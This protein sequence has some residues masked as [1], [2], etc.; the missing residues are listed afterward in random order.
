MTGA[1]L[2]RADLSLA[3]LDRTKLCNANLFR[4]QFRSSRLAATDLRNALLNQTAFQNV[5][6]SRVLNLAETTHRGPSFID[7][8][9]LVKSGILPT[10]F[11]RGCG[12]P[13][14]LIERF[15]ALLG[16]IAKYASCFI[17]YSTRDQLFAERLHGDLQ[18]KGVRCWF[19]QH[20]MRGG[21]KIHE[22]IDEAIQSHSRLLLILS[23]DSMNSEWVKTEIASARKKE[24]TEKRD[25]LFPISLVPF[26]KIR[27][28]KCF[29]SDI[30]KDSAR[31]IREYLIRDFCEWRNDN[32]YRSALQALVIDLQSSERS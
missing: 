26:V 27:E 14:Q 23:E 31:E 6:L 32:S 25:V 12:V 11:L 21:R 29:D 4:A 5:D 22:Q 24:I 17:S 3:H 30:G 20:D 7:T 10:A 9:S 16:P 1:N 18:N 19:A 2:T 15:P 28:W 13:E 8:Q